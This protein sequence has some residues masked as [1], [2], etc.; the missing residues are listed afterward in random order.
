[1]SSAFAGLFVLSCLAATPTFAAEGREMHRT[2]ALDANG[3]VSLRS[4]KGSIEVEP[5]GE[6][7]ADV[8]ARIEPDTS[9][10]T[11]S[12]QRERVRLTEVD[13]DST[14]SR[15]ELRSNYDR[16]GGLPS[17]RFHVDNFDTTCSA[18][19]FVHYRLRI[20]RT[21]RLDVQDHKSKITVTG[22]R[23]PV[24]IRTHKGSVD[25]KG[26]EG[27]LDLSTHKGDVRV[28]FAR[29]GTASRLETYKGDIEI[30]VPR[31]AGF[32]LGARLERS[33]TLEAPF[34]LDEQGVGRRE[35]VY[36]QKVNGGGPRLELSTRNGS[37]RITE[38]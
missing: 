18:Y 31:S 28:E 20:P 32:D 38:K 1:M 15:L 9:C 25:L 30:S 36:E 13:V 2:V 34:P 4:F 24:R 7:Q 22:L 33:G 21:A 26:Y 3:S 6:P 5:W 27:A 12:E 16:L 35:R 37:L 8:F 19:P 17:I 23:S 11:D 29:F 14:S 10:G